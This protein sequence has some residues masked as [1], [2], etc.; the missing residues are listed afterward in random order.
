MPSGRIRYA[1]ESV[2]IHQEYGCSEVPRDPERREA[3]ATQ[4]H[5]CVRP[6][7]RTVAIDCPDLLY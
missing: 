6:M 5:R 4:M 7:H 1:S 3:E 2:F